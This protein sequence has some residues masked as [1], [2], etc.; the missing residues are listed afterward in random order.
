MTS[1]RVV[2][3]RRLLIGVIA[4]VLSACERPAPSP[5]PTRAVIDSLFA[6]F[7]KP[8]MPG[9]S[10]L[11][12]RHD[13]VLLRASYGLA[14]VEQSI[15]ATPATNYRLA[16]L[17]KQ[18]TAT[19]VLLM[20]RDGKLSLDAPVRTY[21][22][23]LPPYTSTVTVRHLLT[24]TSGLWDYEDFVP[25]SQRQQ[26]HDADVLALLRAHAES[27]YFAPG[28]AWRYSNTGY[29]LL[30]LVVERVSGARFADVLRTRIFE[31]LGMRD[32]Y[33]HEE[34]RTTIPNRAWGYTVRGDSVARTDQSNTSAVLGDGG[35]YSSIDDL[36]KWHASLDRA[37][38]V[39]DSLWHATMTPFTL[40]DGTPTSYGFGWFVERFRGHTRLR[41]HGETRGFTNA[42]S[43]F[44]DDGLTV[45]VLTNR[46]GS[47]PWVIA[48][49]LSSLYLPG[50]IP[51]PAT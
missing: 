1:N 12:V 10:V 47:E 27:T 26:V 6:R 49:A 8:G 15:A 34:G 17:T 40:S 23:E 33:A 38:L 30:S 22:P 2:S 35:V 24:H 28:R 36:A 7:A 29:A 19:A 32:T 13:S 3:A 50:E 9:A 14:D 21:L 25:D 44:P 5:A 46:T 51:S 11:V 48:D 16:S 31:P 4:L 45:I 18:F 42:V 39:G 41:H 37:P 20:A 43:R